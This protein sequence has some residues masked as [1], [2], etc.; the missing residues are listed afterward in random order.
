MTKA[1][2][3]ESWRCGLFAIAAPRL[4]GEPPGPC[5]VAFRCR[6]SRFQPQKQRGRPAG[7]AAL[8]PQS[9]AEKKRRPGAANTSERRSHKELSQCQN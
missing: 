5:A 3:G 6:V 4:G 7:A 1:P 2:E 9:T 8:R